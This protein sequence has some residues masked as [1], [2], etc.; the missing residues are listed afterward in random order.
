MLHHHASRVFCGVQRVSC[1]LALQ[2]WTPLLA[3]RAS[4][5]R[6]RIMRRLPWAAIALVSGAALVNLTFM[7]CGS[8]TE[9]GITDDAGNES[10]TTGND[11]GTTPPDPD[12]GTPVDPDAGT[13]AG[14]DLDANINDGSRDPDAT[15]VCKANG[16]TCATSPECCTAN[17][18]TLDGGAMQCAPSVIA[19]KVPGTG[20]TTGTECCTGS[21]VG[22][23]CSSIVCAGDNQACGKSSDCC[24]QNCVANAVGGGA[25]CKT[26]SPTGKT[27]TGGPCTGNANC[28]SNYCVGGICTNPSFCVQDND[29]CTADFQCCGGACD[30]AVGATAGFCKLAAA[31]VADCLSAGELCGAGTSAQADSGVLCESACCSRSCGPTTSPAFA[32]Q[33]PSGCKPT[34]EVCQTNNDCCGGGTGDAGGGTVECRK[35]S[36]SQTYG[37]CDNGKSC[38]PGGGICKATDSVDNANCGNNN[39]CCEP[40]YNSDGG[41]FTGSNSYCNTNGGKACCRQDPLGIPRCLTVAADCNSNPPAPGVSCATAA[42]CCNKPCVGGKCQ[43]SCIMQGGACTVAADCCPGLPC[44]IPTGSTK[45]VCGGT[46]LPDGGVTDAAPPPP[47]SGPVDSSTD[48]PVDAKVCSLFGQTCAISG[49]CCNGVPCTGG[50]CRF[51]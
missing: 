15:I 48:A 34:G 2:D 32:C 39:N 13:D 7:G 20:C 8:E 18:A 44:T 30:K 17:C 4:S 14:P 22:N 46:L 26:L 49:D 11:T 41:A 12:T 10:S 42:D 31:S 9:T 23:L 29:I 19:C 36:P 45:G 1:A 47:D 24:S 37:R 51:P 5:R 35:T 28:A 38:T 16:S 3:K 27:T 50:T 25:S 40:L 21:C 33:P 43:A 6:N